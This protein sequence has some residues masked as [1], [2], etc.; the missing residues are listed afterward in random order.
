[1]PLDARH[2]TA[3]LF[4][5]LVAALS[6]HLGCDRGHPE[7]QELT[8]VTDPAPDSPEVFAWKYWD[9]HPCP[10]GTK[11]FEATPEFQ[12]GLETWC[13]RPNGR[14]HGFWAI[15]APDGQKLWEVEEK[16]GYRTGTERE[17]YP[18]GRRKRSSEWKMSHQV[19][20]QRW[21]AESGELTWVCRYKDNVEE[22]CWDPRK[23]EAAAGD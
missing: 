18:S 9:R 22:K 14:H 11:S 1:M 3:A 16:D 17:W 2:L 7:H 12:D 15:W 5:F 4:G 20:E 21:W 23:D 6:P 13:E 19:G 8:E 10:D